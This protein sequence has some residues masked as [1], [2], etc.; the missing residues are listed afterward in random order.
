MRNLTT[1]I[2]SSSRQICYG[3][4][5]TSLSL[6]N[7]NLYSIDS[8]GLSY[9]YYMGVIVRGFPVC[10]SFLKG[11]GEPSLEFEFEILKPD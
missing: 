4:I 7:L 11:K 8:D 5:T 2:I 1:T 6:L 3:T 9:C 10:S